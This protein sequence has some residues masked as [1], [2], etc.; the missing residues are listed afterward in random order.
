M[1]QFTDTVIRQGFEQAAICDRKG[2]ESADA[3]V[4]FLAK[5]ASQRSFM[6]MVYNALVSTK[7]IPPIAEIKPEEK[8]A[9]WQQANTASAGRLNKGQL[10]ILSKILYGMDYLIANLKNKIV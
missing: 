7:T 10:I 6:F 9:Y 1:G 8:A 5:S 2:K 4:A 3:F